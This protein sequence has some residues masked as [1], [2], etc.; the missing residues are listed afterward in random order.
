MDNAWLARIG[1]VEMFPRRSVLLLLLALAI[2]SVAIR[3][4]L[5]GHERFQADSYFIHSES[6]DIVIH[7]R[8]TWTFHALSYFGY[9]PFSYPSGVPFALAELS[10]LT[11]LPVDICILLTDMVLAI[12]FS[13][14]VFC[15]AREFI[16]RIEYVILAAFFAV[17]G[18]RFVDTTYWNGSAR[19]LVVV[20]MTMVVL[21]AFRAG[22]MQ[23]SR[24]L[25]VT[26]LLGFGCL[27]THHMAVL[28]FIYG[29]GYVVA[30]LVSSYLRQVHAITRRRLV[31]VATAFAGMLVTLGLLNYFTF[32][33]DSLRPF[34]NPGLFDVRS[35]SLALV[36]NLIV[37]YGHQIGFVLIFGILGG[38]LYFR[39]SY[40]TIRSLFPVALGLS[41]VPVLGS[42]LY[43]SM[44]ISAF[45]AIV[46]T[47]WLQ[48]VLRSSG[49][50][51]KRFVTTAVVVFMVLSLVFTVWSVQRW[52]DYQL[53]TGDKIEVSDD[54]FNDAN[55]LNVN[56]ENIS[57]LSNGVSLE[58]QLGA[59]SKVSFLGS[60]AVA[61]ANGD[62]T[63]KSIENNLSAS[64]VPFPG[65]IF[66]WFRYKNE[67]FITRFIEALMVNG[68]A[69]IHGTQANEEFQKYASVHSNL[70]VVV[71]NSWASTYAGVYGQF[72][73]TFIL[74]VRNGKIISANSESLSSY[75][76]YE[77]QRTSVFMVQLPS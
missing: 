27:A 30:V 56:G 15:L 23:Q 33:G 54:V 46:G 10:V 3:Y 4:P 19:G 51:R 67:F 39:R 69:V 40:F 57:A 70:L 22:F 73:S 48:K 20:L 41:F 59:Y 36:L 34:Q 50:R 47:L 65:N 61:T 18:P 68:V 11:G 58:T 71:D 28:L 49:P 45:V 9:Y 25:F 17:I 53:P 5:V 77:S 42:S 21:V 16:Q 52:N 29:A 37:S 32:L 7:G 60:V 13:L 76:I 43:V 44:L 35:Q 6:Q 31:V 38:I 2:I 8:A 26:L 66:T 64:G 72:H 12:L 1:E 75:C 63:K 14:V 55:Y 62:V 74:E 24:L